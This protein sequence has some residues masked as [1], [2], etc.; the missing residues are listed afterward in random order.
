MVYDPPN[1]PLGSRLNLLNLQRCRSKH[2]A[3][4]TDALQQPR[5]SILSQVTWEAVHK[6]NNYSLAA[7]HLDLKAIAQKSSA[8]KNVPVYCH[9]VSSKCHSKLVHGKSVG[10]ILSRHVESLSTYHRLESHKYRILKRNIHWKKN[11]SFPLRASTQLLRFLNSPPPPKKVY[12][13]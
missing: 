2:K 13:T 4:P 1:F 12:E 11:S 5:N 9:G 10:Q 8:V 6:F 7:R 3:A